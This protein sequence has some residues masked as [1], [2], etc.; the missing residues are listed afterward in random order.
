VLQDGYG[1]RFPGNPWSTR[2]APPPA[3]KKGEEEGK[4]LSALNFTF[5]C[6]T[7]WQKKLVLKRYFALGKPEEMTCQQKVTDHITYLP[8]HNHHWHHCC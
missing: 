7:R 2:P 5:K 6:T 1:A 4:V 3:E 8:D